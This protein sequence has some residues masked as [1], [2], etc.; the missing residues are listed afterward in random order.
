MSA[1]AGARAEEFN[2]DWSIHPG[3]VLRDVLMNRGIRQAELAE[4]T[5]LTPKHINQIVNGSIGISSDIAVLLERALDIPA[6]RWVELDVFHSTYESKKKAQ[7]KLGDFVDWANDFDAETLHRH[8]IV[9]P[10]DEDV[11]RIE[12]ILRFFG[13][14][15]PEA[16]AAT[17]KRARVSF[18]RSQAFGVAEKN[19]ALWLRLVELSAESADVGPL[20]ARALRSFTRTLPRFTTLPLVDGF[21]ATRRALAEAG[22]TLVFVREIPETRLCGATTWLNKDS[23]V[24]GI[25][26]RGRKPDIF[27]FS[28]AHE[29]GHILLHAKRETYLNLFVE[30]AEKDTAESEAD[31]FAADT[32]IDN[33]FNQEVADAATRNSLAVIAARLGVGTSIVAGRHGHLTNNW[34]TGAALRGKITDTEIVEL[35]KET[36]S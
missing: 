24:I 34:R 3:T 7:Q 8:Q 21:V 25:T 36:A 9:S 33:S 1:P 32:L 28:I 20:R 29:I 23:P 27:W 13:V 19:T 11:T 22:V 5:G 31:E 15:S 14:A 17:W 26:A 2:P 6:R 12:K 16:F 35:E 10:D 30:Q 18:R 4:R